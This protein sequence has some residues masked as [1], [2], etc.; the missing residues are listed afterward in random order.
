MPPALVPCV[1]RACS[2]AS[3]AHSYARV[4]TRAPARAPTRTPSACFH[5]RSVRALCRISRSFV[6]N[7]RLWQS[8]ITFSQV[9]RH[10]ESGGDGKAEPCFQKHQVTAVS[11]LCTL[12]TIAKNLHEKPKSCFGATE[13]RAILCVGMLPRRLADTAPEEVKR[14]CRS[15][16]H[17]GTPRH[18][19]PPAPLSA[20]NP[21]TSA[22]ARP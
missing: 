18:S 12:A 9:G 6:K 5:A 14:S 10:R 20:A 8:R 4:P 13:G 3:H 17:S 21:R 19:V 22:F 1:L 15:T 7:L 16:S 2:H 11:D